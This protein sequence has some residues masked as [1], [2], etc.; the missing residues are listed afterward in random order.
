MPGNLLPVPVVQ[1][2]QAPPFIAATSSRSRRPARVPG[3]VGS[4]AAFLVPD[5]VRKKFADGWASHVPLTYL[6]NKGCLLK[7][8]PSLAA[9]QEV[10]TVDSVTGQI[11]T[12]T[13]SL[14]DDGE[15]DMTFD[16]WHQAWRRLLDLI[17]TYFPD[18]FLMWE[19]H[20][21]FILNNESR[22]ESWPLYLAY[23]V[24]IRK[25]STQ[26]GIDP[27]V[28]SIGI[29]NDLEVRYNAKK[30]YSLVQ[31]DL[32]ARASPGKQKSRNP[33][34]EG[35]SFRDH[36]TTLDSSKTGRCIFCGNRSKLHLSRNC[37]ATCN[38][39]G[40][41]CF[42]CKIDGKRQAR[43]GKRLCYA[44]NGLSGCDLGSGCSRGDHL[45]TLCGGA[46]HNAQSCDVVA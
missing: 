1:N 6:T 30:V 31:S 20:Y 45:C 39:S 8:K 40:S 43:L 23:D 19:V 14:S 22:A 13:S 5:Y 16:D 29:W 35:S 15:L 33:N 2:I 46:S 10:L 9:S 21:N 7:N 36:Q 12:T 11:Q 32:K 4:N 17:R 44:W 24:E 26:Q 25:R 38:T 28:F 3:L 18:E 37:V 27:S 42:L 34:H 41:P